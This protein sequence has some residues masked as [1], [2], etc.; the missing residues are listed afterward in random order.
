MKRMVF[1]VV[2][3]LMIVALMGCA[4]TGTSTSWKKSDIT[5][6]TLKGMTEE[7][8]VQRFGQPDKT[9]TT[10]NS[11]IFEYIKSCERGDGFSTFIKG[12]SYGMLSGKR[13]LCTDTITILFKRG[14]V[15]DFSY[16]E[17]STSGGIFSKTTNWMF[18]KAG[19]RQR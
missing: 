15:V 14:R 9:S 18:E 8:I 3:F 16:D 11:K 4:T 17:N 5:S 12:A 6:A 7:Q 13:S 19:V 10:A 2:A 1:M